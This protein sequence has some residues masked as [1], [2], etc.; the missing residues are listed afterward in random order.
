[1]KKVAMSVARYYSGICLETQRK[2][3]RTSVWLDGNPPEKKL[4]HFFY[5][6]L[7]LD[8]KDIFKL[9]ILEVTLKCES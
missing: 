2:S 6:I 4:H 1:L 5:T 7:V 8:K 9:D 3:Q